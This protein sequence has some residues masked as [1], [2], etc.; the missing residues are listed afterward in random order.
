MLDKA[1]ER[2]QYLLVLFNRDSKYIFI[3]LPTTFCHRVLLIFSSLNLFRLFHPNVSRDISVTIATPYGL[4]SP[5]IESRWR[6]DFPHPSRPAIGPTHPHIHRVSGLFPRDEAVG[7]VALN[8][9][10]HLQLR[11]K[12]E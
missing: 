5:V 9:H 12:K 1:E 2:F 6:R 4:D 3:T 11:L 10:P 8:T 7:G